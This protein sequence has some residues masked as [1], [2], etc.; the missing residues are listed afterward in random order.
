MISACTSWQNQENALDQ[1]STLQNMRV[2]QLLTN[3][4]AEIDGHDSVPSQGVASSGIATTQATGT[5]AATFNNPFDLGHNSKT[6]SP[7]ASVYWQNNWTITPVSD[8]QDLQNLRALYGFLFR[9]DSEIAEFIENSLKLFGGGRE[10]SPEDLGNCG[11]S[12]K[13]PEIEYYKDAMN[14]YLTAMAAFPPALSQ[15]KGT[16]ATTSA[17]STKG[18]SSTEGTSTDPCFEKF[19]R[20]TP[21]GLTSGA[22]L[23]NYGLIYPSKN[24]V[25]FALRNGLSPDCR[26]YQLANLPVDDQKNIRQNVLFARWLFWKDASGR[27]APN[28]SGPPAG[29]KSL[30]Q[31][32]N[33]E[34]W[35]ASA[36]CL[37]DSIILGINATANS[38]AAAQ[39]TP[40]GGTTPA[41]Q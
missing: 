26:N 20:I 3:L 4:S 23:Q 25:I 6:L 9:S 36:A 27:W 18:A 32:G 11:I 40:K 37:N 31:Y 13:P 19:A 38:H 39:N 33:H 7:M 30:G 5:I 8:P 29:A 10:V 17:S 34:F 1:I 12:S 24:D 15:T 22:L 41:S 2:S 28:P 21:L 16:P 35:T 14:A